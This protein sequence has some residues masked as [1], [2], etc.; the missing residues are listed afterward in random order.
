M[1]ISIKAY[2]LS[3]GDVYQNKIIVMVNAPEDSAVVIVAFLDESTTAFD[4][5]AELL[6]EKNIKRIELKEG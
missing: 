2:E 1:Q 6:V 5:N 3:V 4:R